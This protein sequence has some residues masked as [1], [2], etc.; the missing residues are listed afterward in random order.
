MVMRKALDVKH[1]LWHAEITLLRASLRAWTLSYRRLDW[2][3]HRRF[4]LAP[5]VGEPVAFKPP[6]LAVEMGLAAE[7][8]Y[9]LVLQSIYGLRESPAAWAS[10]R[11]NE[12]SAAR[13]KTEVNGETVEVKLQQLISDN[14]V[15]KIVRADGGDQ[16][17][18]GYF[19]VCVSMT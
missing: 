5:W 4:V 12:L 1:D 3:P 8:D 19:F 11:D 13:W 16:E 17:A 18:L 9:W 7:D 2:V 14:Q 6:A 10:F 15:W